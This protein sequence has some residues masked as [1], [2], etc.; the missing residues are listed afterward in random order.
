VEFKIMRPALDDLRAVV[1]AAGETVDF[2]DA[3][4]AAKELESAFRKIDGADE[5]KDALDDV[6]KA[7]SK[8]VKDRDQALQAYEQALVEYDAQLAW[9]DLAETQVRGDLNTYVDAMRVTIGIRSQDALNREQALY[10]ASCT[11]DHK[12]LSLNF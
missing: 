12:D 5:V 9:R 8:R 10:L 7:L 4:D 11:A 3:E 1:D 6:G 2:E